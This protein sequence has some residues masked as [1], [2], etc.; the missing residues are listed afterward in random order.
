M[1]SGRDKLQFLMKLR[2]PSV[3]FEQP[4]E[5][6]RNHMARQEIHHEAG[7]VLNLFE[8]VVSNQ[9]LVSLKKALHFPPS[10]SKQKELSA[11]L[12]RYEHEGKAEFTP[13]MSS[14]WELLRSFLL[15]K[16]GSVY[17]IYLNAMEESE[18]ASTSSL[19]CKISR[20]RGMSLCN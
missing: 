4:Y 5:D 17:W 11:V 14:S 1:R 2:I 13:T 3:A 19:T 16:F 10:R 15:R 20:N 6:I 9:P 12:K 7:K 8:G 18:G